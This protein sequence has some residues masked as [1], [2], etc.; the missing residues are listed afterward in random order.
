[1]LEWLVPISLYWVVAAVYLGGF[2]LEFEGRSGVWQVIGILAT[3]AA[4]LLVFA[5]LRMALGGV[6]PMLGRIV[7]PTTVAILVFPL[8]AR[9]GFGL[10]GVRIRRAAHGHH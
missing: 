5:G 1:M 2:P 7:L 6:G 4:F 3:F 10:V 9:L 8:L